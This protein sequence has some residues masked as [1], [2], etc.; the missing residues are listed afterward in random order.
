MN[1]RI[2]FWIELIAGILLLS[3]M[4]GI[5]VTMETGTINDL[6]IMIVLIFTFF[7]IISFLFTVCNYIGSIIIKNIK[8]TNNNDH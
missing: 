4:F 5:A 8:G 1:E 6:L 3:T 2:K 7:I